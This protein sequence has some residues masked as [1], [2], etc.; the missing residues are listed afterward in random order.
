M[1]FRVRW[2]QNA[3]DIAVLHHFF[4]GLGGNHIIVPAP[5]LKIP[6]SRKWCFF[7]CVCQFKF[8]L[9]IRRCNPFRKMIGMPLVNKQIN[10]TDFLFHFQNIIVDFSF[11]LF[12]KRVAFRAA[13]GRASGRG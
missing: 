7:P 4:N 11:A 1:D 13:M 2:S 3:D 8:I 9:S 12:F 6:P 5:F 10:Q